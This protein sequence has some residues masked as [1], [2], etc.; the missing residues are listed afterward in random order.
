M[1]SIVELSATFS[2]I[3]TLEDTE[4]HYFFFLLIQQFFDISTLDNSQTVTP[5]PINH[6]IFWKNAKRSFRWP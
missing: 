6:T 2:K 3:S 4:F 1:L 5:K